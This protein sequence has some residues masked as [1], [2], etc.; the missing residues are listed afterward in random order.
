MYNNQTDSVLSVS[1]YSGKSPSAATAID[2]SIISSLL[3]ERIDVLEQIFVHR[4]SI[5]SKM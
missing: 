5:S 3:N 2:E 1:R 4:A